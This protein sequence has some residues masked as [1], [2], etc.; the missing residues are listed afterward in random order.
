MNVKVRGKICGGGEVKL[1][2]KLRKGS[3]EKFFVSLMMIWIVL[4]FR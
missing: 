3:L 1:D 4:K 2:K